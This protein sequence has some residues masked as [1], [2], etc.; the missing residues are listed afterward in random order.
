ME[1]EAIIKTLSENIRA[2]R[3][4][5]KYSQDKLAELAGIT[6]KYLNRI[7]NAKVNPTIVVVANLAKALD[8]TIDT[9]M[10]LGKK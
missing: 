5:K 3:A 1:K 6:Q 10:P 8:V 7:E 4:R 9:L 2:E